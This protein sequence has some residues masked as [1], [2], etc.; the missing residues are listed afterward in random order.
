MRMFRYVATFYLKYIFIVAF[1]LSFL[2]AGLDFLQHAGDLL[3][4]NIK[5]LYFFYRSLFAFNLLFPLALIFAMIITKIILI[6]SNALL[7]FYALGYTK[8]MVLF[9]F[10]ILSAL[11]LVLYVGLHF[12]PVF[13]DSDLYAKA[14]LEG[15]KEKQIKQNLFLKYNGSYV[16]IRQLRPEV[17]KAVDLRIYTP[18]PDGSVQTIYGE[19]AD[20]RQDRWIV[21]N[22]KILIENRPRTLGQKSLD[23]A[24]KN[25][26]ETL[27]GFK[28]A[29]LTS[30]FEGKNTYTIPAAWSAIHL[31]STQRIKT[32]K[33]R[34]LLYHMAITPFFAH[35]L[36]IT[37]FFLIPIY[38]RGANLA[39]ITVATVSSTLLVW[40]VL[41]ILFRLG[42][43]E[44][45]L[46]EAVAFIPMLILIGLVTYVTVRKANRF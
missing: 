17:R 2:F 45:L 44:V 7:S 27:H 28:P 4:F 38:A 39:W 19:E 25:H 46:P 10:A 35:F 41:N 31:L 21:H 43:N 40:G 23:I 20:F 30:V 9:P 15:S 5:I 29:L 33:F 24:H 37:F 36:I 18:Q 16:Y 1:A 3:G 12:V 22:V 14:L 8:R 6:R 42:R 13:T 34:N 26:I 11:L 32:M